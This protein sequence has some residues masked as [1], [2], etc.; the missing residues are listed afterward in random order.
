ME[1]NP[2][3]NLFAIKYLNQSIKL[4]FLAFFDM[5]RIIPTGL[6]FLSAK[7]L[8]TTALKILIAYLIKSDIQ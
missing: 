3:K 8:P 4:N 6:Y 1:L 5:L 2:L 7:K